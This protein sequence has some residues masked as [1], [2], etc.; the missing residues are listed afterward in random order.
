MKSHLTLSFLLFLFLGEFNK[1]TYSTLIKTCLKDH[2]SR[3]LYSF[4]ISVISS[5]EF[6]FL[7]SGEVSVFYQL[8]GEYV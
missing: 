3:K 8:K 7:F 5:I 6:K 4:L 1:W 2:L